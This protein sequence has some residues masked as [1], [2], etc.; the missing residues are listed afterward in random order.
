MANY[1][2]AHNKE[3]SWCPT[4]DCDYVFV[5]EENEDDNNF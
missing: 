1:V 2:D 4:A 5:L 3:V